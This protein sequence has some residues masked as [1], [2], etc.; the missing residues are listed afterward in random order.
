MKQ[1]ETTVGTVGEVLI[2]L[3]GYLSR[4]SL[5]EDSVELYRSVCVAA[6]GHAEDRYRGARRDWV[7]GDENG[8]ETR[9]ELHRDAVTWG[10]ATAARISSVPDWGHC[11]PESCSYHRRWACMAVAGADDRNL[12]KNYG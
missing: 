8:E 7:E 9:L 12:G 11:T 5:R 4:R 2:S 3:G 1:S 10:Q 6:D